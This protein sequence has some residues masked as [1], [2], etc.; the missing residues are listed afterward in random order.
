[1][2]RQIFHL[3]LR[4]LHSC[5]FL[6]LTLTPNSSHSPLVLLGLDMHIELKQQVTFAIYIPNNQDS[7]EKA[8]SY[9]L[10]TPIMSL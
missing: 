5:S 8:V 3:S 1:M 9:I 6:L 10:N 2:A 7:A 4:P